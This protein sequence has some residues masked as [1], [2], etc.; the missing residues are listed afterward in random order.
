[1]DKTQEIEYDFLA[2]DSV[3][4]IFYG[5]QLMRLFTGEAYAKKN[6]KLR[7][8]KPGELAK[9]GEIILEQG[10][11]KS[12][13]LEILAH[14]FENSHRKAELI[15]VPEAY[16]IFKELI[17]YYGVTLLLRFIERHRIDSWEKLTRKLPANPVRDEWRNIGGQLM[18][19]S[20]VNSLVRQ[21]RSG[22]IDS[23]DAVHAFYDKKSKSYQDE[24]FGHAFASLLEVLRYLLNDLQG[25]YSLI[26]SIKLSASA[27][28]W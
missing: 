1:M 12:I 25:K 19:S 7:T 17:I 28:G 21:I 8:D 13:D 9:H 26:C 11:E 23:W 20:A 18:K 16:R 27:N 10:P 15:K 14:G 2:P 22:K 3:N 24:K 4:E 5:L 6:K